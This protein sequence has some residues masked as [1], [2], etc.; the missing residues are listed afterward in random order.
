MTGTIDASRLGESG[1]LGIHEIARALTSSLD[2]ES[3]LARILREIESFFA[4]E[5]SALMLWDDRRSD[6]CCALAGGRFGPSLL[7]RRI[8][9]GEGM[10]GRV[11][12]RG[13]P[14]ILPDA[15]MRTPLDLALD[16]YVDFQVRSVA[17]I[18]LR[19][20]LRNLGVIQ[21]LNVPPQALSEYGMAFLLVLCDF[22]AIAVENDYAF[23]R[24]QELTLLDDCTGLFNQRHFDQSLST[25]VQRAERLHLPMSLIFLDLDHF[26]LVNDR[27]GHQ[28]GSRL[29][30]EVGASIRSNVR[31]I[32]AAFRYG[33]DEF[34]VLLPGTPRP[35]AVEVANRL[36]RA[37]RETA[38]AVDGHPSLRL[39]ASFGVATYPEDGSDGRQI[40][41]VADARMYEVKDSTRDGVAFAGPGRSLD[42][43]A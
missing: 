29:L 25:E 38:Y 37:F 27:F 6:L 26:K 24:M 9:S 16:D 7:G 4:P 17:C 22:A 20:R 23:R 42:L 19:S 3:I 15:S 39:T 33:G 36:L 28:A 5:A 40:L 34:A 18:P 43:S 21:L 12:E 30:G 13:H 8:A 11:M 41:R 32:D 35:L 31:S 1:L 10:V 14:V 2:L